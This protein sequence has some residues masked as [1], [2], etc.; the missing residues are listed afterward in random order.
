[1]STI[2]PGIQAEQDA[3]WWQG[4]LFRI[5]G[6]GMKTAGAIGLVEA[7]YYAGFSPP[8][9]VHHRE[10]EAWYILEGELRCRRGD[11]EFTARVGDF[12]FCPRE[13]PHSFKALDGGARA[14]LLAIPAGLEEMFL[15]GGV[16][17]RDPA[18][19]P[20]KEFDIE[21][22]R[23]LARKYGFDVIGPPLV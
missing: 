16:P 12:V 15:E 3:V 23:A 2:V 6:R 18:Q 14:L 17:V 9:H 13:I 11:E 19:P 10:D 21:R 1:M 8:L 20:P 5:K 22:V 4:S 7:N